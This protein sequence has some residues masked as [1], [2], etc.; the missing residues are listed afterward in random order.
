M[1][2]TNGK[3]WVTIYVDLFTISFKFYFELKFAISLRMN[4]IDYFYIWLFWN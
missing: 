4:F 3:D 2:G 1:P